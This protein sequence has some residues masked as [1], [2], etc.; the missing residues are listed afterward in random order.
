MPTLDP[1]EARGRFAAARVVRMATVDTTGRP[2]VVPV[3][4]ALA[5]DTIYS[6]VD[7][8]PKSTPDLKRLRNLEANPRA[9]LLADHYEE[10]WTRVWWARADGTARL[11]EPGE[12]EHTRAAE[13]LAARYEQYGDDLPEGRAIAIEVQRWSG[14]S[15]APGAG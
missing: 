15:W 2:H 9:A 11:H 3:C 8:K 4:F 7:A 10:S 5:G 14:W 6:A 12:P 13:L 1:D